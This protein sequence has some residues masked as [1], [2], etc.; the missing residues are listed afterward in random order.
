VVRGGSR[1]R[2]SRR[3]HGRPKALV[4][5][6]NERTRLE[7]TDERLNRATGGGQG[8]GEV[9]RENSG[10]EPGNRKER[11]RT[12]E[13]NLEADVLSVERRR[14]KARCLPIVGGDVAES[15]LCT[16]FLM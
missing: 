16:H 4:G 8:W 10:D 9:E 12:N 7:K 5:T 3:V 13:G 1:L 6:E 2:K 15:N 14:Q 11:G